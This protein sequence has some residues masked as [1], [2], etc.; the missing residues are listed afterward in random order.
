MNLLKQ[1]TGLVKPKH[2]FLDGCY[3]SFWCFFCFIAFGG[4]SGFY[5]FYGSMF[6]FC[7]SVFS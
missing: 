5:L 4:F 6:F 3:G 7:G 1:R 2:V